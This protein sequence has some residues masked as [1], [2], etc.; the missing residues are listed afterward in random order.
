MTAAQVKEDRSKRTPMVL[1]GYQGRWQADQTQVKVIEKSRRIGLSWSEA[2]EDALLAATRSGMD[3]FYIGYN[4]DMAL[5]F[6][7]D[8][9]D[10]AKFYSKAATQVEE[11]IFQDEDKDIIA[12]RIRFASG[13]KIVALSSRPANLRG[14]QGKIVIDE[15]AFHDDLKGLLKAAIALL[16]WGGQVV[17]ISTHDGEENEFNLLIEEI[18]AGRKPYSLHTVTLDDALADGLYKRICLRTG[19]KWSA[20]AEAQW[21]RDLIKNYG[22]DANEELFCIPSQGGGTYF[23]RPVVKNCMKKD[24]PTILWSQQTAWEELPDADREEET[25]EWLEENVLPL[26]SAMAP[27]RPC[28]FGEDFARDQNLTVIWPVQEKDDANLRV[29]FNLELF[30]IP[31]RQQEQ[32]LFYVLDRLPNFRGGAMDARGNGQALAEYAMQRYGSDHIHRIK[33]TDTW[34]GQWFP[35]Y[36]ATIQDR[37]IDIPADANVMEDHRAIKKIKGIPKIV[38]AQE[39][40]KNSKKQRHGDSAIAGLMA[41]YAVNEI[42]GPTEVDGASTGQERD[43]AQADAFLEM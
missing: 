32:V 41:V 25:L 38:E 19:Q 4:K 37:A 1:L 27:D 23:T 2:S 6:I 5:E 14:K 8:C 42:E 28:W 24:I 36:R 29:A 15:A 40:D 21:R 11:F 33:A 26:L 31:F 3:V 10:W 18:K 13:H 16:M 12:F 9:G 7:E 20:R 30:N 43:C 39:K 35:I 34:Y 22:D 17:V